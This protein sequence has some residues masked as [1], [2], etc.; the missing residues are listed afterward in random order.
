MPRVRQSS[1][2]LLSLRAVCTLTILTL[3]VVL[4]RPL[5]VGT[6]R[7]SASAAACFAAPRA[8]CGC[9]LA[10]PGRALAR[11][12]GARRLASD[13]ADDGA[14]SPPARSRL[15][16]TW[17]CLGVVAYLSY[18]VK[19]VV[20]IV[21]KGVAAIT[22]P[23]QWAFLVLTLLFFAYVEGYK[24]FQKGFS[25]RVV[26]RAWAVSEVFPGPRPADMLRR[27]GVAYL[28]TSISFSIVSFS[29]LLFLVN[30][31]VDVVSIL[32]SMGIALKSTADDGVRIIGNGAL[33]YAVHKAISPIRFM[34]TVA[35]TPVV[36]GW[37][38]K[39]VVSEE[40]KK[41][42]APAWH[43]LLAPAFCI[44]YFHG[45][46]RRVISSWVVTTVIF[47]VVIGVKQLPN[48]YRGIIDAGVIVG[49]LWGSVSVLVLFCQSLRRGSPPAFNPALPAGTPYN[50]AAL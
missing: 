46:R 5:A 19:K 2:T 33:A 17:G 31:G 50:A 44:G 24:G 45:T 49:L 35:M 8:P 12:G 16:M 43:K 15:V 41:P 48:P 26:S 23:W 30:K 25:P 9:R 14:E 10:A 4:C 27:Y 32:G 47:L 20:P 42:I 21:R 36:A 38:G 40:A 7:W 18:G 6:R 11:R 34:P 13:A 1:K 29:S 3:C 28:A 22:S 37:M 39:E